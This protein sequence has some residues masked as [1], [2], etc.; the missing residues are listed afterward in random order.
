MRREEGFPFFDDT[1]SK[2]LNIDFPTS[3]LKKPS[4]ASADHHFANLANTH[5]AVNYASSGVG[6]FCEN[7]VLPLVTQVATVFDVLILQECIKRRLWD[8]AKALNIVADVIRRNQEV[9]DIVYVEA[10]TKAL[11]L[12]MRLVEHVPWRAELE[13]VHNLEERT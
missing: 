6:T 5:V 7:D 4:V 10:L 3:A 8:C 12:P 11:V 1:L 9:E 13:K 2:A